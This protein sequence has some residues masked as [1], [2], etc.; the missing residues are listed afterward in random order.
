MKEITLDFNFGRIDSAE[1][2]TP[3]P[4]TVVARVLL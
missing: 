1:Q 3:T 4:Y 2:A